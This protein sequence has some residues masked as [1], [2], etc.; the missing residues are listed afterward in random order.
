M[1]YLYFL[2]F[3]SITILSCQTQSQTENPLVAKYQTQYEATKSKMLANKPDILRLIQQLPL[4]YQDAIQK[5]IISIEKYDLAGFLQN[6]KMDEENL[7][8]VFESINEFLEDIEGTRNFKATAEQTEM[9]NLFKN[10]LIENRRFVDPF[11]AV[12]EK[13][14]DPNQLS[15]GLFLKKVMQYDI[16]EFVQN[17]FIGKEAFNKTFAEMNESW[18]DFIANMM[19]ISAET[20]LSG[21]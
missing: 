17:T 16:H 5:G 2:F 20:E 15:S 18:G 8:M 1:K 12:C 14:N 11:I 3:L 13:S 19:M 7:L 10:R 9:Y 6:E 21:K 4:E